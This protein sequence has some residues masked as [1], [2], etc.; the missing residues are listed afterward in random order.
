M[1]SVKIKD[2]QFLMQNLSEN[3]KNSLKNVKIDDF[4]ENFNDFLPLS[5]T[6]FITISN[7][8]KNYVSFSLHNN[9]VDDISID[10]L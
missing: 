10:R 9:L 4:F 8:T 5:T 2:Y 1:E 3:L 6:E 7:K